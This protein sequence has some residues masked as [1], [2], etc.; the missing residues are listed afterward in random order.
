ML[1]ES[2]NLLTE[3]IPI[4]KD[5]LDFAKANNYKISLKTGAYQKEPIPT[6]RGQKY[7][8]DLLTAVHN[9]YYAGNLYLADFIEM[10]SITKLDDLAQVF[11][12]NKLKM[13]TRKEVRSFTVIKSNSVPLILSIGRSKRV[14]ENRVKL[15]FLK[16]QKNPKPR[17]LK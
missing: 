15:R 4:S 17:R 7:N 11:K 2:G 1:N 14:P 16:F 13:L 9:L 8:L 12:K 10:F 5:L 3:N 6:T